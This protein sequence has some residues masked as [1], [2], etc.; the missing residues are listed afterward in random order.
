MKSKVKIIPKSKVKSKVKII[1]KSKVKSKVIPKSKVKSNSYSKTIIGS[2]I[3]GVGLLGSMFLFNNIKKDKNLDDFTFCNQSNLTSKTTTKTIQNVLN[4]LEPIIKE[5]LTNNTVPAINDYCLKNS[6]KVCCDNKTL[7]IKKI[8]EKNGFSNGITN[9]NA[10]RFFVLIKKNGYNIKNET[11]LIVTKLMLLNK[12]IPKDSLYKYQPYY[13]PFF[14]NYVSD[15]LKKQIYEY[16]LGLAKNSSIVNKFYLF[17]VRLQN[18]AFKTLAPFDEKSFN[19]E[20]FD[21]FIKG[22]NG[23]YLKEEPD[24][25]Y[26]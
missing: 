23:I 9:E 14:Y 10:E 13:Y 4:E 26:F 17:D 7:I 5:K 21:N 20:K 3:A 8:L 6:N 18:I 2:A 22:C 15:I 16:F 11:N 1:P 19:K 25:K 12:I 24:L